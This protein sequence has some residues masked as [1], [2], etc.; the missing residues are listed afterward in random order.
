[1]AVKRSGLGKGTES[2]LR[3]IIK[4]LNLTLKSRTMK[5]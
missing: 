5:S 3:A 1:M 2:S 4:W